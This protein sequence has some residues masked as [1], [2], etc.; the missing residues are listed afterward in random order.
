MF[1]VFLALLVT[2]VYTQPPLPTA[3]IPALPTTLMVLPNALRE[4]A[5]SLASIG[6][7]PQKSKSS[8]G[9]L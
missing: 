4:C 5:I 1:V 6:R 2:F 8:K 9:F 3:Y 7:N